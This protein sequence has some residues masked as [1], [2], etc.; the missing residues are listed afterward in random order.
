MGARAKHAAQFFRRCVE[1]VTFKPLAE[2]PMQRT[3]KKSRFPFGMGVNARDEAGRTRLIYAI[4]DRQADQA[5]FLIREGANVDLCDARGSSPLKHAISFGYMDS[6]G[7]LLKHGADP[8]IR[9][10]ENATPLIHA[11]KKHVSNRPHDNSVRLEIVKLLIESNADVSLT[12]DHG[13]TALSYALE[14]N[15]P[16]IAR[17]LMEAQRPSDLKCPAW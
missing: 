1:I 14:Y 9:D 16:G 17:L 2:K 10:A 12:D 13:K 6:V 5:S 4:M 7:L 11:S 15:N 8:N 3:G